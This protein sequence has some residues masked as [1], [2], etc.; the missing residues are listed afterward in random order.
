MTDAKAEA[1]LLELI[2]HEKVQ[3]FTL[4][5]SVREGRWTVATEIYGAGVSGRG[6][7]EGFAEA[8]FGQIAPGL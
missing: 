3:N 1:A 6:H 4:S 5:I 2:R 7:G 8:W